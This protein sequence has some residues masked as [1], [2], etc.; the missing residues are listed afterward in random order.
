MIS[1]ITLLAV[2]AI[3]LFSCVGSKYSN[4]RKS[5]TLSMKVI[6]DSA[7]L[8]LHELKLQPIPT[9][10]MR[11][12]AARGFGVGELVS[13]AAMGVDKLIEIDRSQFTAS[14]G[15][16]VSDLYFYDQIS[17]TGHFDPTGLQFKG[18]EMRRNIKVKKKDT[19]ALV[20]G[21]EIDN[22]NRYEILNSSVFR[23]RIKHLQLHYAK[24]KASTT[25]WYVPW[26]W[27]NKKIDDKMNMDIEIRFFT[28]YVTADGN[29]F[30]NV[31]IGAFNLNLRDMPLNPESPGYQS[32]Y[33]SLVGDRLGGYS[34]LIPRS[35]GYA[36]DEER[37][38][39]QIF[40]QGNY[41]VELSVKETGKEKF[42][43]TK[44]AENSTEIIKEGS[45]QLIKLL[46]K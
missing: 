29:L 9:L 16:S 38:L 11:G 27:G 22:T 17:N 8:K 44:L 33:D 46:K 7:F 2:L 36:F 42:I 15:Q 5:E 10:A 39:Q 23:L 37:E 21:F 3:G 31:L 24:A 35:C 45:G 43:K 1:R 26:T 6:E 32:Y 25:R 13:L 19:T 12:A 28:S 18:I 41:R 40:N 20:A 30:D 14:Y 34:F 4:Q